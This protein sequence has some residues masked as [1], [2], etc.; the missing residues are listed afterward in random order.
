ISWRSYANESYNCG[1]IVFSDKELSFVFNA[2]PP[3]RGS[4]AYIESKSVLNKSLSSGRSG[5]SRPNLGFQFEEYR[6]VLQDEVPRSSATTQE[7]SNQTTR[8]GPKRRE[9]A[10]E[11]TFQHGLRNLKSS[12][13]QSTQSGTAKGPPRSPYQSGSISTGT[14]QARDPRSANRR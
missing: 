2:R 7:H 8:F 4:L 13:R 6:R 11:W 3:H 12:T 9:D 1:F 5:F 10:T 14:S